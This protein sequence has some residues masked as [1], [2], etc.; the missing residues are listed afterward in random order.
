MRQM[1]VS[2]EEMTRK[3]LKAGMEDGRFKAVIVAIGSI[4]QHEDH[5]P[6]FHDTVHSTHVAEEVARRLFPDVLVTTPMN[7][8]MSEH[9]MEIGG[10]V[11]MKPETLKIVIYDICHGLQ[12][13]GFKNVLVMSGHAGNRPDLEGHVP[14]VGEQLGIDARF[15]CYWDVVPQELGKSI[16]ETGIPSHAAEFETST[17]LALYPDEVRL[18]DL[19]SNYAWGGLVSG[20]KGH[21]ML[22]ACI[23]GVA[24]LIG[25]MTQE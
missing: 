25:E 10:A 18:E 24:Q 3:E 6:M 14:E 15:I 5:L 2:F 19:D 13:M 23:D 11:S 21:R 9:H 1:G 20:E 8:G 4:E 12:R 16:I 22:E 7:I 17:A